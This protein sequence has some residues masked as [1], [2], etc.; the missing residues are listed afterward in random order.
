MARAHPGELALAYV[1]ARKTEGGDFDRS[2]RQQQVIMAIRNRILSADLLPLLIKNSPA[3]YET[4]SSGIS[5]NLTLM[6]LIRIAW[7]AQQIEDEN[8]R[9]GMIGGDQTEFGYSYDGQ[10]IL[11]PDP[12]AIRKLRDEIFTISGPPV[13]LAPLADQQELVDQEY[14]TVLVLNGTYSPGLASQTMEYLRASGLNTSDPGNA[15]ER[16]LVTTIIDY[17]GNPYTVEMIVEL[18]SIS[19]ENV[20]HR[21]DVAGQADIVVIAGEDWANDNPMQ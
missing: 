5:T 10:D 20:Y 15:N 2:Q 11:R 1:R 9:Q 16:Y 21:Y 7:I 14:A 4:M 3:I 19:P 13:P 17:T 8:L 18:M 12:D 6:Q